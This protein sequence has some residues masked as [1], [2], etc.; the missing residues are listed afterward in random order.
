MV[1]IKVTRQESNQ[2]FATSNY[3]IMSQKY[4]HAINNNQF[5]EFIFIVLFLAIYCGIK[6]IDVLH[7]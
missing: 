1:H 6:A 4:T 3:D 7:R 2:S 5:I